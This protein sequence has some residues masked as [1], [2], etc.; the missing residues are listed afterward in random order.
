MLGKNFVEFV[1]LADNDILQIK[2]CSVLLKEW[3]FIHFLCAIFLHNA[4]S[5]L[6][7]F[8]CRRLSALF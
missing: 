1:E 3:P 7:S 2:N 4:L 6:F 5:M 8:V